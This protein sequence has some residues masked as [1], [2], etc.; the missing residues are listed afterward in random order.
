M[1]EEI[2]KRCGLSMNQSPPFLAAM[3]SSR[4]DDV[5][6]CV[7]VSVCNFTLKHSIHLRKGDSRVQRSEH[8]EHV[9]HS[10]QHSEHVEHSEHSEHSGH[11]EHSE[12]SE[13]SKHSEHSEQSE[14]SEHPEHSEQNVRFENQIEIKYLF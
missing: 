2:L 9:E 5:T 3:S 1:P 14:H 8:S 6:N 7:C 13:H 10:E 4:S 11:S 12:H